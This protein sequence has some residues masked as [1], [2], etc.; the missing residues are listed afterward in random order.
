VIE[1]HTTTPDCQAATRF[2][3]PFQVPSIL[4]YVV[5]RSVIPCRNR[6]YGNL[7]RTGHPGGEEIH[8][9]AVDGTDP[10]ELTPSM[11]RTIAAHLIEMADAISN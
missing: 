1:D 5:A 8:L 2:I 11:A 4:R 3:H 9:I 10:V 6:R 7:P